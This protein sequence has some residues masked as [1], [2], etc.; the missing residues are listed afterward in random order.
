MTRIM[1]WVPRAEGAT[2]S[3]SAHVFSMEVRTFCAARAGAEHPF[4][5]TAERHR[6]AATAVPRAPYV[7]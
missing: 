4:R 6:A 1:Q 7:A 3:R 2:S 5:A